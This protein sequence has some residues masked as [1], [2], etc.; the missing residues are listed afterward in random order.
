M[1]N[2]GHVPGEA[3][4]CQAASHTYTFHANPTPEMRADELMRK[5]WDED[6]MGIS[7]G[8]KPLTPEEMLA[9]RRVAETRCYT[10]G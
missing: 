3:N 8:D 2:C 6:V 9:A 7:D 10:D 1:D 4:E 5:M